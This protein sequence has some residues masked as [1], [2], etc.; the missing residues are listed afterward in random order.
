MDKQQIAMALG[1]SIAPL[2]TWIY[3]KSGEKGKQFVERYIP[4]GKLKQ[5]LLRKVD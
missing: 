4:E 2:I 5:F 1:L 3:L